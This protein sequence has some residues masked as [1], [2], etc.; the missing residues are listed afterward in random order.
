MYSVAAT[1]HLIITILRI[2]MKGVE[3]VEWW[4]ALVRM[5]LPLINLNIVH[6]WLF[7]LT[8]TVGV[9]SPV[10]C[11]V[12]LIDLIFYHSHF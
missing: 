9:F 10:R 6:R 12:E 11:L 1:E 7:L 2:D 8:V 5:S 4:L 3:G